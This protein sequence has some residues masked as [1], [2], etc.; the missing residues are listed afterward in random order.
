[1]NQPTS[2]TLK[3]EDALLGCVMMYPDTIHQASHVIADDFLDRE[4]ATLW[5]LLRVLHK[6]DKDIGNRILLLDSL[7]AKAIPCKEGWP[8]KIVHQCSSIPNSG[9]IEGYV[10]IIKR[11]AFRRRAMQAS[12]QL[13][14]GLPDSDPHEVVES[15]LS[16]IES[17]TAMHGTSPAKTMSE[18]AVESK[19][20]ANNDEALTWATGYMELDRM[21]GGMIGETSFTVIGA[22]PSFGKTAFALN[23]LMNAHRNGKP[24]RFLYVCMEMNGL[25]LFD[26]MVSAMAGIQTQTTKMLRLGTAK[27]EYKEKYQEAYSIA[28]DRLATTGHIIKADGLVDINDVGAL[29]AKHHKHIDGVVI[30]YLQQF[31]KTDNRQTELEKLNEASIS[32]KGFA[33]KYNTPMIALSQFNRG[34]YIDG[35]KPE[36]SDLKGSGQ[37]EQ[38]CDNAWLLW[39]AKKEGVV[40]EELELFNAKQRAGSIGR[41]GLNFELLYGRITNLKP[42]HYPQERR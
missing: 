5:G 25:E 16:D 27:P 41:L 15:F 10:T 20:S 35:K 12:Q 13:I 8:L 40:E 6:N 38:D 2:T 26:R 33:G 19:D 9:G 23:L 4:N 39:R 28:V 21:I 7:K 34:G 22:G 36:L 14:T 37:I 11:E 30:D 32:L 24:M 42:L 3:A 17:N 18:L 31:K 29:V 1:L